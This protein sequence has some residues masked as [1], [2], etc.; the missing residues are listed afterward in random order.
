MM[1]SV[2]TG[3]VPE[4]PA[5]NSLVL[6]RACPPGKGHPPT[7]VLPGYYNRCF[8]GGCTQS[9]LEGHGGGGATHFDRRLRFAPGNKE[10]QNSRTTDNSSS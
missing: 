3:Y 7:P 4:P 9:V 2:T 5:G 6:I 10:K 1:L 8:P